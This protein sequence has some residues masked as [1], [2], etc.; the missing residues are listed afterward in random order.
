M[1]SWPH[2]SAFF[3]LSRISIRASIGT[4][5]SNWSSRRQT[6]PM[7]RYIVV[8]VALAVAETMTNKARLGGSGNTLSGK[9]ARIWLWGPLHE[10]LLLY[11]GRNL[12]LCT[13]LTIRN[14]PWPKHIT[15]GIFKKHKRDSNAAGHRLQRRSSP[16]A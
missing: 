14:I 1:R 5:S 12:L 6:H 2:Y 11:I 15:R 9:R 8:R 16:S 4:V 10:Y 3:H 13:L 7:V